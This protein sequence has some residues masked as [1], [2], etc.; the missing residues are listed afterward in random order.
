MERTLKNNILKIYLMAFFQAAMVITAIYVPLL[1]GFGLSMSEV[2]QT[3]AL[4]ALTIAVCEVPSGYLADSWGRKNTLILGTLLSAFSF[5]LLCIADTFWE[6]MCYELVL[7]VGISM[8]SGADLALLY[9][10]QNHLDQETKKQGTSAHIARLLSLE[11]FAGALA[12]VAA[13]ILSYWSLQHV[14]VAQALIGLAPLVCAVTLVE[15]PRKVVLRSHCENALQVKA[16]IV[17]SPLVPAIAIAIIVFSLSAIYGFWLYQK[18]WESR[19]VPIGYFGYLWAIH[20]IIRAVAARFAYEVESLLGTRMTLVVAALLTVLGFLGMALSP[21][22]LG[23]FVALVLPVTRGISAVILIDGLNKRL[24]GKFR[25]TVNS[26]VSLGFRG[27]FIVTAPLLGGLVD[28]QGVD[29]GLIVL[30][31][32]FSPLFILVLN[33]LFRSIKK[34]TDLPDEKSN[35]KSVDSAI[36][37]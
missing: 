4:F 11:G 17:S 8:N 14:V 36:S 21:G 31:A 28:L 18:F 23:V 9:D 33:W 5:W 19:T 24:D 1:Q 20:C 12:A 35:F 37:T 25:A 29:S 22:L 3:Q 32:L 7:G 13:G 16:I 26:L 6:F 34:E 30:A 10:T 2:M 15:A 27:I